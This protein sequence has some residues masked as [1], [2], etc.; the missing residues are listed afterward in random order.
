M[1]AGA[2]GVAHRAC[3]V[4]TCALFRDLHCVFTTVFCSAQINVKSFNSFLLFSDS[5]LVFNY[6]L[7]IFNYSLLIFSDSLLLLLRDSLKVWAHEAQYLFQEG[8]LV[9]AVGV[10]QYLVEGRGAAEVE[11]LY[12]VLEE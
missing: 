3:A 6:G 4:I 8:V 9:Q 1:S 5:L 11:V 10:G 2:A 7:L 12:V